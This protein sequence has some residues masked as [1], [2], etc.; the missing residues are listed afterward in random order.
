MKRSGK[1]APASAMTRLLEDL[2]TGLAGFDRKGR[3]IAANGAFYARLAISG[4][5][6]EVSPAGARRML[7]RADVREDYPILLDPPR[8]VTA[9]N[10]QVY[11]LVL[12]YHEKGALA[13]SL[14][15]QHPLTIEDDEQGSAAQL[16][17][18]P[19]NH[20]GSGE[21]LLRQFAHETRTL[22]TNVQGFSEMMLTEE[23]VMEQAPHFAEWTGFVRDSAVTMLSELSEML[24]LVQVLRDDADFDPQEAALPAL[25]NTWFGQQAILDLPDA[26]APRIR[27]EKTWLRKALRI[28]LRDLQ[29]AT[30]DAP[31]RIS[32]DVS[33]GVAHVRMAR[34]GD[35]MEAAAKEERAGSRAGVQPLDIFAM[36]LARAIITRQGGA[37]NYREE[38]GGGAVH[39]VQ[40][41][42]I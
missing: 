11:R 10:G 23:R 42:T 34:P 6:G 30:P 13:W 7:A 14:Q 41:P 38:A 5:I 21:D 37:L 25:L 4:L 35:A 28:L 24:E 33:A 36:P 27:C 32:L 40:L 29:K 17:L 22:L 19:E 2:E 39:D 18:F 8:K 12:T 3:L 16:R 31:V 9:R 15:I 20:A 26:E 1:A